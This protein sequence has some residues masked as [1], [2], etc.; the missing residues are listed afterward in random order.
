MKSALVI[1]FT[2]FAFAAGAQTQFVT[3]GKIEFEKKLNIHKEIE[4]D[5]WFDNFKDKIPKFQTTYFNLYFKDGKTR[6]EK[7]R[8]SDEPS[9]NNFWGEDRTI[10]DIVY[11]D[12]NT[13][14]F[15]KKQ[16]VYEQ[17]F[18]LTDSI[19]KIDWKLI[20]E[21]RD[22]AGFEC[23]KAVGFI[24]DTL[25]IIA[26]YT[27]QI[28]VSGGPLSYGNLPG[29]IMGIA[30]PRLNLTIMATKLEMVE[31]KNEKLMPPPPGKLKKT[32]YKELTITM[33]KAMADWGRYGR[34]N[35]L[36]FLL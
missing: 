31:P 2:L 4:G 21:T 23:R 9:A 13:G 26:F 1:L 15:Q 32:D 18:L 10:D 12:L 3:Q 30:V 19:R 17:N 24:L 8:D 25:Y 14:T 29:M 34:K 6:Y 35:L 28:P 20:N 36:N 33:Q 7:G 22:I 27:D 16:K 11:T 5:S